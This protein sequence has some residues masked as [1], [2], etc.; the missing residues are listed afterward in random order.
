[1]N[2]SDS[3]ER[4]STLPLSLALRCHMVRQYAFGSIREVTALSSRDYLH[5]LWKA[6]KVPDTSRS[7]QIFRPTAVVKLRGPGAKMNDLPAEHPWPTPGKLAA[8]R[9][10]RFE[11]R[12][13]KTSPP[14][15]PMGSR[16]AFANSLD[17]RAIGAQS[18]SITS[19]S[20][21]DRHWLGRQTQI[22]DDRSAVISHFAK[23]LFVV[24]GRGASLFI[25]QNAGNACKACE[26]GTSVL[27]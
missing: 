6:A 13:S 17:K 9:P 26:S 22:N 11:N 2:A 1:M 23:G 4:F 7:F 21:F 3:G 18:I 20:I 19:R 24:R 5:A 15:S 10:P 14:R 16:R 27:S 8:N 25:D 12:L